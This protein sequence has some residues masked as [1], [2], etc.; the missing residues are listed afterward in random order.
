MKA[1]AYATSYMTQ[2][3]T[4][5]GRMFCLL[6]KLLSISQSIFVY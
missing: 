2:I 6:A 4:S 5:F 1:D 3:H